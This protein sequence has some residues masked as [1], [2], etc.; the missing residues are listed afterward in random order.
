MWN[1]E[2]QFVYEENIF[3]FMS[4]ASIVHQMTD[5]QA[6]TIKDQVSTI[7]DGLDEISVKLVD[8]GT[9]LNAK[10]IKDPKELE[11]IGRAHV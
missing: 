3:S 9:E 1:V 10:D 2:K 11:E 6:G 7:S 8:I 5:R 4:S